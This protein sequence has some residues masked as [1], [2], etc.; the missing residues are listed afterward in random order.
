MATI[1]QAC[2]DFHAANPTATWQECAAINGFDPKTVQVSYSNILGTRVPRGPRTANPANP[3]P[4]R[5]VA[6]A[7]K[8]TD[9]ILRERLATIEASLGNAVMEHTAA[10][11][12]AETACKAAIALADEK[13][14]TMKRVLPLEAAKI[15][16][17]LSPPESTDVPEVTESSDDVA[18]Q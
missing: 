17:F 14:A 8:S 5:S 11:A 1:K 16:M 6:F 10:V 18:A 9:D 15:Q 7:P 12:A 2:I 13:L 3:L 4:Q